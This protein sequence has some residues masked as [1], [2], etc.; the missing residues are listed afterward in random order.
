MP[1]TF[2]KN[3]PAKIHQNLQKQFFFLNK[4]RKINGKLKIIQ[5]KVFKMNNF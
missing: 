2:S 4:Q 5:K 1:Y 3:K